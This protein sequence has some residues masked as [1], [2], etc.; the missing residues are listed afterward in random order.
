MRGNRAKTASKSFLPCAAC[1]AF[2]LV[3]LIAAMAVIAI[4]AFLAAPNLTN[5]WQQF[6]AARCAS[7]MRSI[8][9]ALHSYLHDHQNVWP[10]G[11][12]PDAGQEWDRFWLASLQPYGIGPTT[13]RC[14]AMAPGTSP[15]TPGL[16]YMPTMF[17]PVKG[18]A[19]RWAKHPWLMERGS[20]HGQGAL[21]CFQDGSIK[22]FD[23]VLAELGVR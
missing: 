9:T 13:W 10:Q 3:E 22:S 11:P 8:T 5:A 1:R 20:G 7:N 19:T 12:K 18:I 23:K 2:T 4:L 17:P 14:P 16:H 15:D 21:I 6:Q